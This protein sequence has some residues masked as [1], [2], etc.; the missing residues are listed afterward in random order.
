MSLPWLERKQ[1]E[2]SAFG[3]I[4]SEWQRKLGSARRFPGGDNAREVAF[5]RQP[6]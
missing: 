2:R 5:F 4:G 6:K 1:R 3:Y